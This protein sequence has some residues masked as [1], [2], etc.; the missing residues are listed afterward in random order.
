MKTKKRRA[1]KRGENEKDKQK[2]TKPVTDWTKKRKIIE[3][4]HKRKEK[5]ARQQHTDSG[6]ARRGGDYS[7]QNPWR[8]LLPGCLLGNPGKQDGDLRERSPAADA[9]LS[10]GR[11]RQ[12]TSW[13]PVGTVAF[14]ER[15]SVWP[16]F[17]SHGAE[18]ER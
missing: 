2:E 4:V 15:S 11:L 8:R 16:V 3:Q 12:F 18:T 14:R 13:S 9:F 7:S 5:G 17:F 6:D 10:P 1:E